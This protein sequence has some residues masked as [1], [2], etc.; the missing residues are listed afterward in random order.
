MSTGGNRFPTG[1]SIGS[2]MSELVGKDP[3]HP[4]IHSCHALELGQ[5]TGFF[6]TVTGYAISH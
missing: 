6:D 3:D 5:S 1:L 2:G 4:W